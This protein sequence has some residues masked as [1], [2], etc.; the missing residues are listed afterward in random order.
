MKK[1]S[2]LNILLLGLMMLDQRGKFP[3]SGN[4]FITLSSF[5]FELSSFSPRSKFSFEGKEANTV[6]FESFE[7]TAIAIYKY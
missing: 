1:K 7:I 2:V 3:K 6:L 4:L 5:A